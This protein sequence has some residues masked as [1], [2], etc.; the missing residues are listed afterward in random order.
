[1]KWVKSI[2]GLAIKWSE[3]A[4]HEG[5]AITSSDDGLWQPITDERIRAV[6]IMSSGGAWLYGDEGLALVDR[7]I[8]IIAATQDEIV[9]Y[10]F[11]AAHIFEHLKTADRFM[12]SFIGNGHM[13]VLNKEQAGRMNHFATAFFG[14]YLQGKSDYAEYFSENFVSQFDDL[15]WGVYEK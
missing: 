11:E 12:V 2:C 9:P 8:F 3:F 15:V 14:Y 4:D 5:N 1:V 7:P 10:E 13:M 6:M